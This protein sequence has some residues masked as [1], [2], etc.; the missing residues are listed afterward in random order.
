MTS[1]L[2][3]QSNRRNAIRSTGPRTARGKMRASRNAFKHGLATSIADNPTKAAEIARLVA[4]IGAQSAGD[5]VQGE[6][7]RI[8]VE[9]NLELS[10]IRSIRTKLIPKTP[11]PNIASAT[12]DLANADSW[13]AEFETALQSLAELTSVERYERRA[14]S[15]RNRA[16]RKLKFNPND[17]I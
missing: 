1:E 11:A 15:R 12:D 4:L 3:R 10:R 13:R 14:F 16:L 17:P 5:R 2:Q 9:A 8:A 6:Y 7:V